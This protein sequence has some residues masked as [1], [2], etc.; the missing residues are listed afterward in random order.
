MCF[1]ILIFSKFYFSYFILIFL[2]ICKFYLILDVYKNHLHEHPFM[3]L[4]GILPVRILWPL[5]KT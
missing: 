4:R 5:F 3:W 1:N 2:E